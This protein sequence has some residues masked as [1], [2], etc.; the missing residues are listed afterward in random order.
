MTRKIRELN[1][2][3]MIANGKVFRKCATVRPHHTV[4]RAYQF[5]TC[6]G[7]PNAFRSLS[8]LF[9]TLVE[10]KLY[11]RHSTNTGHFEVGAASNPL[12]AGPG[13]ERRRS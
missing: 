9:A 10:G 12:A 5:V 2:W 8:K 13:L 1:M 6:S 4:S 3:F 11:P 7:T